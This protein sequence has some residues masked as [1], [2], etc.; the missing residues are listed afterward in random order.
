MVKQ[1]LYVDDLKSV[2]SSDNALHLINELDTLLGSGGF[3]LMKFSSNNSDIL[4]KLPKDRLSPN[5]TELDLSLND[6]PVQKTLG[7]WWVPSTDSFRV[8]IANGDYSLTRRGM[9]SFLSRWFDPL[10]IVAPF[11]LPAKLILRRLSQADLDWDDENLPYDERTRWLVWEKS[12]I[13]LNEIALP[14]CFTGLTYADSV[15]LHCFADASKFDYGFVLYLLTCC[16]G[17][18]AL[19]FVSGRSKLLPVECSTTPRAELHAANEAVKFTLMTVAS[20]IYNVC[21]INSI[22]FWSDSQTV[23]GYIKN[24][25][26]RLPIYEANRVKRILR[27]T[28]ASQWRWVDSKRNSADH[29]SRGVNPSKVDHARDWI[30]GPAFLLDGEESWPSAVNTV[31]SMDDDERVPCAQAVV[32]TE[33][34]VENILTTRL[35]AHYSTLPRLLRATAWWLRVRNFLFR[36]ISGQKTAA[37]KSG[38]ICASEYDDALMALIRV[39]HMAEFTD[40]LDVLKDKTSSGQ[41]VNRVKTE[42]RKLLAYCPY[43]DDGVIRIGGR[44]QRSQLP[45]NVKH[46]VVLPKRHHLTGLIILEAHRKC[47]H[48]SNNYVMNELTSRYYILGGKRIVRYCIRGWCMSCRNHNA[49]P[50][51]QV[52]APLPLARVDSGKRPFTNTGTDYFGPFLIRQGRNELKRYGCIFSCLATRAIHLEIAEDLT[53]EAFLMAYRC[54]HA[55]TGEATQT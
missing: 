24:P 25:A 4:A 52:M 10:G 53:T 8:K 51:T 7:V 16:A 30:I 26:K 28:E 46:P 55:L 29:F 41:S 1:N 40:V 43:I 13:S 14:R 18:M 48:F 47:G 9:L 12:L 39:M 23:L 50:L 2:E 15:Q 34:I 21:S 45:D 17:K 37:A 3:R 44:L 20:E 5:I 22:C 32:N 31:S 33:P 42:H 54:F 35:I 36:R 6:V 38:L 11:V 19:S 27:A 49:T